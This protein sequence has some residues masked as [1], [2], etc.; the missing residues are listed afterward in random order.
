MRP[1]GNQGKG[2]GK[3]E[4]KEEQVRSIEETARNTVM[5]DDWN[6]PQ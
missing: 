3:I 1:H 6:A 4:Q 2:G 5:M